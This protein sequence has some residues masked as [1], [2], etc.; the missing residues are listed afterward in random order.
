MLKLAINSAFVGTVL[1]T[2]CADTVTE[3]LQVAPSTVHPLPHEATVGN[4]FDHCTAKGFAFVVSLNWSMTFPEASTAISGE[5]ASGV[6][7]SLEFSL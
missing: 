5:Q 2:A 1:K 6:Q 3:H 7:T 4:P